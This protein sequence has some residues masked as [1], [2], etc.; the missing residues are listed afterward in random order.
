M[1]EER[2]LDPV[3]LKRLRAWKESP[4]LFVV[5]CIGATPSEQQAKALAE[6]GKT[7]RMTIRSGH[8]C[9]K[10]SLAAWLVMWFLSTRPFAKVVC[11]A[12]TN[13]QLQDMLW[14]EVSK[15]FRQSQVK[16][17]FVHQKDIFFHKEHQKEWWARIVSAAV[18]STKEE[19]AETLAGF[20][21]EHLMML[22]DESSGVPDPVFVPLEGAM[23]QED[24]RVLLIGNMTKNNGYFYD[25]HFH[26]TFSKAWTKL[27]WDSRESTNVKSGYCEYMATKY[28][29]DSNVFRIRVMGDPPLEDAMT[30]IP[31]AWAEACIGNEISVPEDEPLYLG[32]DVARYGDD[33]S[34]ILPRKGNLIQ[35]W[36]K[37]DGLNTIVLGGHIL[38]S[39]QELEAQGL[40]IDEIGTGAGVTDWLYKQGVPNLFGINT[41]TSSSDTAKY[42]RLRDELWC[43]VRDKCMRGQYSF[44]DIIVRGESYSM[45]QELADEL[46]SSLYEYNVHGG[47]KVETKQHMKINRGIASPNIADALCLSEYF[48]NISTKVFARKVDRQRVDRW[49][50]RYSN[51]N[52]PPSKQA[53]M[54]V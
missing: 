14:P 50:E 42:S 5:E 27:C 53:W 3:V 16:D 19:Q 43:R 12:P 7:K 18:K 23:T 45:G 39:Y 8:G 26:V 36:Q 34:V 11:T 20:H 15:W 30:F 48:S 54:T 31:L 28:G 32:V 1:S 2:R 52:M 9:G 13:R 46:A 41:S 51:Y 4:L 22:V 38:Q 49:R 47:V 17:E 37:F 44:P 35:P 25:T 29:V 40:G 33:F 21:G 24:N 10:T 6:F